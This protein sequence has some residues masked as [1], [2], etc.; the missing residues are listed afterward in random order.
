M[1]RTHQ[2]RGMP[3]ARKGF[4][5][6]DYTPGQPIPTLILD[7]DSR[8]RNRVVVNPLKLWVRPFT[9]VT[10]PAVIQLA[11]GAVSD[12]IPMD[13]D[14]RG[15][16]EIFDAFYQT[17]Q[18]NDGFTVT[19][20]DADTFGPDQRPILMNR[21]VHVATIASGTGAKLP[22]SGSFPA[23]TSGGRPF[24][25][26]ETYWMDVSKPEGAQ[27]VAIFRNLSANTQNLRFALHGR[28]W[29][30]AQAT[31]KVA[32]RMEE[33]FRGRPRTLPFFYTTD[34]LP[35]L[36]AN[37]GPVVFQMR[38][39]DDAWTEW[40]NSTVVSTGLFNC[41]MQDGVD[42]RIVTGQPGAFPPTPIEDDLMFGSGEF[43]FMNWESTLM[44]PNFSLLPAFTDISG[45]ANTIWLT[46]SC[47]KIF[48]DPRDVELLR[49]GTAPG[50]GVHR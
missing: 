30:Y 39:G 25:W 49:P 18:P 17:D 9:L 1:E 2:V 47:R 36:S 12:P 6:T 34:Q 19:L 4:S 37:Q 22:L 24:R 46:L 33:I 16:F 20:F 43:P 15:H 28:R 48:H 45:Q 5:I 35:Q 3:F 13:I 10:D 42:G 27:V 11:P 44:E 21:E 41:T 29:Y 38:L 26:P 32:R 31:E 8:A 40:V 14:G 23:S 7:P 50:D